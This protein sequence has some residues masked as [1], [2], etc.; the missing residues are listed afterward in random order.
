MF[1]VNGCCILISDLR[2][3]NQNSGSTSIMKK[4]NILNCFSTAYEFDLNSAASISDRAMM[5]RLCLS[6][7]S[8]CE[9]ALEW[10]SVCWPWW[11]WRR[12]R[13]ERSHFVIQMNPKWMNYPLSR[14]W[15]LNW[16]SSKYIFIDQ[17]N[18]QSISDPSIGWVQLPFDHNQDAETN[19]IRHN[20]NHLKRECEEKWCRYWTAEF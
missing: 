13:R 10:S 17:N 14:R 18:G 15:P 19:S 1:D 20:W 11:S 4:H 5:I 9:S 8:R 7:H 2:F 16:K 12:K 3:S 6:L